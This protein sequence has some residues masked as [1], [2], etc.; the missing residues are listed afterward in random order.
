[1]IARV[2]C[3]FLATAMGAALM[4]SCGPGTVAAM[5]NG[6][7]DPDQGV[8]DRVIATAR[9]DFTFGKSTIAEISFVRASVVDLPEGDRDHGVTSILAIRSDWHVATAVSDSFSVIR[10]TE[11]I[12]IDQAGEVAVPLDESAVAY[13]LEKPDEAGFDE[14]V[15]SLESEEIWNDAYSCVAS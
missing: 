2:S 12:G 15:A 1:M 11:L 5:G 8:L 4:T 13:E 14:W 9:H 7:S 6:C 3:S 10:G